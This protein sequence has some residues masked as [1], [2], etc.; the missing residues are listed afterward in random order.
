MDED[1]DGDKNSK[2]NQ[3]CKYFYKGQCTWGS[4]CRFIHPGSVDKG[5]YDMFEGAKQK[6]EEPAGKLDF[7]Q[8][9]M[10]FIRL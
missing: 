1:E 10:L 9:L 5:N 3:I 2:S 4:H 7:Q 8:N 6:K